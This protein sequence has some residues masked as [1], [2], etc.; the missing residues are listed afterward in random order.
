MKLLV[1]KNWIPLKFIISMVMK[2]NLN[3]LMSTEVSITCCTCCGCRGSCCCWEEDCC[4]CGMLICF[5]QAKVSDKCHQRDIQMICRNSSRTQPLLK[6]ES[7]CVKRTIQD[8]LK[9]AMGV[10]F[11]IYHAKVA[12]NSNAELGSILSQ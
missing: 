3:S 9:L 11:K 8:L 7:F 10:C 1:T 2:I 12:V 4:I 6:P 5:E